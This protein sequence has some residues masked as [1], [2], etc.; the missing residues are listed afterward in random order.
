MPA[1]CSTFCLPCRPCNL[2]ETELKDVDMDHDHNRYYAKKVKHWVIMH[3][4]LIVMN[5]GAY[6][7]LLMPSKFFGFFC[8]FSSNVK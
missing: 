3:W 6:F 1:I 8:L 5:A 7:L 2:N 4:M